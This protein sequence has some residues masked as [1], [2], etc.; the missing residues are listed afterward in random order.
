MKKIDHILVL[1][2]SAFGDVAIMIPVIR[3]LA[4]KYPNL[5][6]TIATK[7]RYFGIFNEFKKIK[8]FSVETE[9]KHKGILGLFKLYSDLK[10]IKPTAVADLH[11]VLRTNFLE[12]LFRL[13]FFK[14]KRIFKGR[15]EKLKLIAKKNKKFQPLTPTI[16][17]YVEV[18]RKLGFQIDLGEHQF[19][20]K[21][22][23]PKKLNIRKLSRN[24]KWVGIAPFASFPGKIYPLD[25]MQKVIAFLQKEHQV[26]LFG[27][28]KKEL[29]QILIWQT[30]YNNVASFSG[31]LALDE[32]LALISNL[33]LMISMDSLNGH[34]ATNMGV[35]VVSIWGMTHPFLGFAP[36]GQTDNNNLFIDRNKFPKI[37]TSVYGDKIPKGYELAFRSLLAKDVIEKVLEVLE[38]RHHHNQQ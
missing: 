27:N 2:F 38:S 1:R 37:P 3:C 11:S 30:A 21:L 13:S 12:V 29:K 36:W 18:F 9:D 31:K 24:C 20:L 8:L 34:L 7:K 32:E 35:K 25:L 4:L 28:G 16:Y 23:L 10:K 5:E 17:R 15:R 19:P 14:Y 33:D 22:N 26:F 6:L